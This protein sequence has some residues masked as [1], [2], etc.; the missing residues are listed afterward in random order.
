MFKYLALVAVMFCHL[1]A[2]ADSSDLCPGEEGTYYI[3]DRHRNPKDGGFV[4]DSADI[5]N[6]SVFIG[7]TAAVCGS[8]IISGR[9]R[10]TGNAIISGEAVVKDEARVFGNARVTDNAQIEGK[11]QIS[12]EAY[13]GGNAIVRGTAVVRAFTILESGTL[14]AGVREDAEDPEVIAERERQRQEEERRRIEE[15]RLRVERER[16]ELEAKRAQVISL[17]KEFAALFT[18]YYSEMYQ[19]MNHNELNVTTFIASVDVNAADPICSIQAINVDHK[20]LDNTGYAANQLY[21]RR[22]TGLDF[23]NIAV[24]GVSSFQTPFAGYN[25]KLSS[26]PFIESGAFTLKN[27]VVTKSFYL[28]NGRFIDDGANSTNV[29]HIPLGRSGRF[30]EVYGLLAHYINTITSLCSDSRL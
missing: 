6:E 1:S 28:Q 11:A 13:V 25:S 3:N 26:A 20:Y 9:A 15:E 23:K 12:G 2:F 29:F 8:A 16:A 5:E 22:A 30:N 7:K 27:A 4:S 19:S 17:K 21:W 14:E 24:F 18:N 10:I